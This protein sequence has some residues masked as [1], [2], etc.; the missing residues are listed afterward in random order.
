[1]IRHV[2]IPARDPAHV[3]I[4]LAEIMKGRA[5]HFPGNVPGAYMAV[6]GDAA[7][8][9]I[10]VYP[11]TTTAEPGEGDA[12]VETGANPAPPAYWP[13]HLLMTVASD[14]T[15]ILAIGA[16][17]GWRTRRFGR[18]APGTPPFFEVI[19]LWVENSVMLE[20]APEDMIAPYE[21]LIQMDQLEAA[22]IAPL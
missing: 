3:T 14:E 19:E 5:F 22:G 18:G 20:L 7:G 9:M 16:R 21:R 15:E 10:E 17:E 13:F 8:T 12:P 2:S 4:V 6:S 11:Y 1:M